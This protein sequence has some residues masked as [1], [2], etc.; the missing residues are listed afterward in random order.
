MS[1]EGQSINELRECV[2][3]IGTGGGGGMVE[4]KK[5]GT[6]RVECSGRLTRTLPKGIFTPPGTGAVAPGFA[7]EVL[8]LGKYFSRSQAGPG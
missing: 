8:I 7:R 2:G 1:A 4:V 5:K 3:G 6:R